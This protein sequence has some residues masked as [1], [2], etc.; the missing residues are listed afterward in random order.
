[1]LGDD[2][3]SIL[4]RN[5]IEDYTTSAKLSHFEKIPFTLQ[6]MIGECGFVTR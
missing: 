4:A 1:M 5:L 3:C 6:E 2:K